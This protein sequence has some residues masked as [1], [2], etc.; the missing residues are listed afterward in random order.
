MRVNNQ[1]LVD[2]CKFYVKNDP[3][4]YQDGSLFDKEL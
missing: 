3:P 4:V 2:D 1:D